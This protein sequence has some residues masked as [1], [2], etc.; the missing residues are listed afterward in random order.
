[1]EIIAGAV[2]LLIGI[3]LIGYAVISVWGT[4]MGSVSAPGHYSIWPSA[5]AA[6]VGILF[7]IVGVGAIL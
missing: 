6:V 4:A 7:A 1:M 3:A 2:M 5:F